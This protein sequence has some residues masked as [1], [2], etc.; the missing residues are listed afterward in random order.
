[1]T[2]GSYRRLIALPSALRSASVA[3]ARLSEG[4]LVVRFE[5]NAGSRP[6]AA[7]AADEEEVS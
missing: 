7:T 4:T 3:E 5:H 6:V 2:V 1:M